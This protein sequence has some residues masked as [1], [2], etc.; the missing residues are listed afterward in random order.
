[1]QGD[2]RFVKLSS[3]WVLLSQPVNGGSDASAVLQW[4]TARAQ[5]CAHLDVPVIG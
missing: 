4:C 3:L 1:M 5:L 2:H